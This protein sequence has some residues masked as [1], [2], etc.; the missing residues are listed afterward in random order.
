[1]CLFCDWCI[2]L[3]VISFRF[4]HVEHVSEFLSFLSLNNIA[5]YGCITLCVSIH[6]LV[7]TWIVSTFWLLRIRLL[8][9]VYR[10]GWVLAFTSIVYMLGSAV[11]GSYDNSFFNFL[12]NS[13]VFSTVAVPF[14][15]P[16]QQCPGFLCLH[17]FTNTCY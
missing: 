7:G 3:S 13:L 2:S 16:N 12:R 1:M 11:A 8:W 9:C 4:I 6:P 14:Y 10:Y 5:L 17:V 15:I